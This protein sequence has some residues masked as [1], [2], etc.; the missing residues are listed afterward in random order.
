MA[1][2]VKLWDI[3]A[4][5]DNQLYIIGQ[6]KSL[7]HELSNSSLELARN[8]AQKRDYLFV[9]LREHPVPKKK[10]KRRAKKK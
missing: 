5:R 1:P 10:R 3:V 9:E 8:Y 4:E 6:V 7:F 2:E